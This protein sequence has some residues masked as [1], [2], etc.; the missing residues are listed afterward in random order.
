MICWKHNTPPG[1]YVPTVP[2]PV[3]RALIHAC[4]AV[5]R[6]IEKIGAVTAETVDAVRAALKFAHPTT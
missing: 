1:I 4:K 5:D 6:D 2:A 3:A